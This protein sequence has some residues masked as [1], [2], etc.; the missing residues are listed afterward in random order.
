GRRESALDVVVD[1]PPAAVGTPTTSLPSIT[2]SRADGEPLGWRPLERLGESRAAATFELDASQSGELGVTLAA[3]PEFG[4]A[5]ASTRLI[6]WPL[7]PGPPLRSDL[8]PLT[9]LAEATGGEVYSA[10]SGLD[11]IDR[12]V[13]LRWLQL[14]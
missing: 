10:P 13:S 7:P 9:V 3:A 8:V 1:L 11:L 5:Q 14:P 2:F 4:H 12:G 6:R